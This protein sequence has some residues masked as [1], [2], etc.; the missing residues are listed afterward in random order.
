MYSQSPTASARFAPQAA[1]VF[2]EA[3]VVLEAA[4]LSETV[5]QPA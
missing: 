3:A 4:L 1:Q 2:L 5:T